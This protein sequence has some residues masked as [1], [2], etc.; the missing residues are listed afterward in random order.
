MDIDVQPELQKL[1][2]RMTDMINGG[3]SEEPAA[4]SVEGKQWAFNWTELAGMMELENMPSCIDLGVSME[5]YFMA[6][7][8]YEA[9]YGE[10]AAG[11]WMAYFEG[12]YEIET[13]DETS[14]LIWLLKSDWET[15]ELSRA[16]AV[17]Y[18]NLTE[19]TCTFNAPDFMLNNV[20]ATLM[21]E[22]VT[23]MPQGI[24]M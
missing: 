10:E 6:G 3:A 5:N 2:D 11:M 19:T 21:T 20:E 22:N 13:T 15:G 16:M 24:A 8:D 17:E 9:I 23:V 7:V 4:L 14:G 12:Y 18:Y 1:A